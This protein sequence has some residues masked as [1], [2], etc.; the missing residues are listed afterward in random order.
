MKKILIAITILIGMTSAVWAQV[1]NVK[2][3]V[4][5]EGA[6]K[7]EATTKALRS[8]I[9]QAFGVFVSANTEIL[10]DELVKDEIATVA[11]GN[12]QSFNEV[13]VTTLPNGQVLVQIEAVVSTTR[14]TTYARGKGSKCE[15]A[16]A[17]LGQNIKLAKLNQV[18]S[19]RAI[20]HLFSQCDKIIPYM[21]NYGVNVK[22]VDVSGEVELEINVNCDYSTYLSVCN[23]ISNT[24][25]GISI[26]TKEKS[27]LEA[28]GIKTYSTSFQSVKYTL[29]KPFPWA[30]F[31]CIN[32]KAF[33][34]KLT[35]NLGGEYYLCPGSGGSKIYNVLNVEGPYGLEYIINNENT[36]LVGVT[37]DTKSFGVSICSANDESIITSL[38]KG[39]SR[40]IKLKYPV[41]ELTKITNFEVEM[42]TLKNGM[43]H[44][45]KYDNNKPMVSGPNE[46]IIKAPSGQ[47]LKCCI[48]DNKTKYGKLGAFV[49]AATYDISGTLTIPNIVTYKGKQY[50]VIGIAPDGFKGCNKLIKVIL[51]GTLSTI[52]NDAFAGCTGLEEVVFEPSQNTI[53]ICSRSFLYCSSL[54]QLDLSV[55][56]INTAYRGTDI[57]KG[58]FN[59]QSVLLPPGVTGF[60]FSFSG[61]EQSVFKKAGK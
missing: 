13:S 39:F 59:L 3:F 38:Q 29:Y 48:Y 12:I 14:L 1:D 57:F 27:Q 40:T 5:G 49:A 36:F 43:L 15:F 17:L 20:Y 56:K 4:S 18:N 9:E 30:D 35:E 26:S 58:C 33:Y 45:K 23:I 8:A 25:R 2:L 52:N 31:N 34:M 32:G 16:G 19:E 7:D 61:I 11:S 6:T 24:L 42:D 60:D 50:P 44:Y 55:T 54:K 21:F 51:P 28:I 47:K 10:N 46:Q 37:N 41:D 22:K 53:T